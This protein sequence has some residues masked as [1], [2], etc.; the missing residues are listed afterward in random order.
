MIN[1]EGL[2]G[3]FAKCTGL[4]GNISFPVLTSIGDYGLFYIFGD[5]TEIT[6]IN[7]PSLTSTDY[8]A[9]MNAF[10]NCT[11]ITKVSFPSLIDVGESGLYDTFSGC[12][13]L[14]E[15]HFRADAKSNIESNYDY[16]SKFGASNATIYFDL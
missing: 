4:T 1:P 13:N 2:S 15:I 9:M 6:N 3:T 5:C 16:E 11:G 12:T 10:D 14:M 8:A 7:F